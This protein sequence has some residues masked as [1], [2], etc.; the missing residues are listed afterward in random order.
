MKI[1]NE[2]M[3]GITE[4]PF[5]LFRCSHTKPPWL[6][7]G[8]CSCVLSIVEHSLLEFVVVPTLSSQVN[9]LSIRMAASEYFLRFIE[10]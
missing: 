10:V 3:A 5:L 2:I 8:G 6:I 9:F 4:Y 7:I 1:N